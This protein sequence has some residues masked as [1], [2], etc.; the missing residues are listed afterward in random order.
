MDTAGIPVFVLSGGRASRLTEM[1]EFS[2]Q[3]MVT[4]GPDPIHSHIMKPWLLPIFC[5][6]WAQKRDRFGSNE[7][8]VDLRQ[9]PAK[10]GL[11]AE[12]KTAG[13][14]EPCGGEVV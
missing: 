13:E 14:A 2:P 6:S 12:L 4:I 5:T 10:F 11:H 9:R 1:A 8:G 3:Q 7:I